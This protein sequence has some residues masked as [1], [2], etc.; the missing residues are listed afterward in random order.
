MP[1]ITIELNEG[2][3]IEQ[4]RALCK[5][6]TDVIVQ[7]CKVRADRVVITMF[8]DHMPTASP[9]TTTASAEKRECNRTQKIKLALKEATRQTPRHNQTKTP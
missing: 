3:S 1:E 9:A 5:G 7:T 6:I 2:R 4:K 8:A